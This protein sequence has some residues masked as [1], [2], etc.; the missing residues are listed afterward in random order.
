LGIYNSYIAFLFLW[1][2]QAFVD[3]ALFGICFI[4]GAVELYFLVGNVSRYQVVALEEF[5]DSLESV[6]LLEFY[7]A[8]VAVYG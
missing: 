7:L 5:N 8:V 6:V 2:N 1:G 3:V 4:I